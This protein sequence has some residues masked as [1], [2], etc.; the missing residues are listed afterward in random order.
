MNAREIAKRIGVSSRAIQKRSKKEKWPCTIKKARGGS[1]YDY[2]LLR[3]PADT[4][5][6]FETRDLS[7][8]DSAIS[9]K[10]YERTGTT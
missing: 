10:Q 5:R 3:L 7:P 2:D 4:Q 8:I 6:H 1:Y 9:C